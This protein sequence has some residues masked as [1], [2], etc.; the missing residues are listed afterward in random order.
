MK[1]CILTILFA[2]VCSYL[3]PGQSIEVWPG[4]AN[5]NG[6]VNNVDFLH[7]GLAYNYFGPARDSISSDWAGQSAQPWS[8]VLGNGVNVAYVDANGDGLVNYF[9]DAF[10]LY[11]HYGLTHGIE[12]PDIFPPALPGIDPPLYLD[13]TALPPAVFGGSVLSLPIVLGIS[14]I[15]VENLYGLAF[16]LHVDP[17]FVDVDQVQFNF[18]QLSWANPDNDRIYAHYRASDTRLDVAWVRTDH[19]ERSGWGP[20]GMANIIII[21][22]VVSLEQDFEL[23]IDSIMVLDKF[24]NKT[25]IAGDTIIIKVKPD[26]V[27]ANSQ[28]GYQPFRV[29]PNP[30]RNYLNLS[31]PRPFQSLQLTNSLGRVVARLETQTLQVSWPLPDLPSGIYWLEAHTS[32]GNYLEKILIRD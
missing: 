21:D 24:G 10:P 27:V 25:A 8:L 18:N 4:D 6:R 26:Q 1:H 16:S 17:Q 28:P 15:P 12:T 7:L 19:N 14:E 2:F 30:A 23:R 29:W 5:N 20:L 11:V 31:A 3:L 9:Y 13:S 32:N 22:D